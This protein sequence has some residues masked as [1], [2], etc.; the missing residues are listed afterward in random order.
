MSS[1][2]VT[3]SKT[4]SGKV[5]ENSGVASR[6]KNEHKKKDAACGDGDNLESKRE[7]S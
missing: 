2:S 5:I 6:V 1:R 3:G 7:K 4:L